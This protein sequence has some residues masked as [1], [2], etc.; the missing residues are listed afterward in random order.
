MRGRKMPSVNA[1]FEAE[2][3]AVIRTCDD[4]ERIGHVL[5]RVVAHLRQLQLSYEVIVADEGSGDNSV[6]VATMCRREFPEVSVKHC[7][8]GY[9]FFEAC[10][11]AHGKILFLYDARTEAPLSALGYA[12]ERLREGLDAVAVAERY[13][14]LR[15]ARTWRAFDSLI[16]ER[17]PSVIEKRFLRRAASL[18]LE[19]VVTRSPRSSWQR[20]GQKLGLGRLVSPRA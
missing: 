7:R 13:L 19:F 2:I 18:G 15:R 1:A 5:R 16:E 6:F 3:T 10:E 9:G 11:E 4:E 20:L 12:V 17:D 14:V 8:P